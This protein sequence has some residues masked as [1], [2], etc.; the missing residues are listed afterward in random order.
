MRNLHLHTREEYGIENVRIFRQWEKLEYK[1]A[2]F[3]NHRIFS[4]RC[5]KEDLVPVSVQLRSNV[6]TPR[7]KIITRKAERDLLNER[8]RT[9]NNTIAMATS[10]R[11]TCMNTLLSIFPKEIIDE[12]ARLITLRREAYYIKVKNRQIAKLE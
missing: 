7:A 10:E 12:C 4:L 8:I 9:I 3:Q 6:K 5:L 11:D 1:M 2:A